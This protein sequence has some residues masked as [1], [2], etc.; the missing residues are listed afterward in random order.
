MDWRNRIGLYGSYFFGMAAIGFTLPYLPLYLSQKGLSD[1]SIGVVSTLAALSGLAQFPI[2]I[3]S[4]RIG[5]RKPF[6]IAALA[7]VA[8][9]TI[10][11][12]SAQDVIWLGFLVVLFAENGISR[13]VVESLSGA[14]AAALAP[15]GG[16]G[17]ALG[18]L[19][20]WKPIGIVIMALVGSW[21]SERSGV[22]SILT[23]I[24]ILQGLAVAAA[25]LIHETGEGK[26]SGD[27]GRT[28]EGNREPA[29]DRERTAAKGWIPKDRG[30]WAFVAAMILY[31]AANAP[32][33]V[34]LGLF[35]KRDLQAPDRMLAYAFVVSMVAWMLVVWPAGWLADRWGR[36]PLL[37]VGWTI[38]ALRLALVALVR[39]P[40]LA[41]ANQA[42]DGLGN[43]L[44]AVVAAAWMT[45]RLA[46]P[47]RAGEA[48]VIVGS[49]LV[50]GSAIG[51]AVSGF[52]VEPL[53]FRGLFAVLA[54][55][56]AVATSI[57]VA[58]VPETTPRHVK[59]HD[60]GG[61]NPRAAASDLAPSP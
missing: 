11:L 46:D 57:V 19:R 50:L 55:V 25:L 61:L 13:A 8:L 58:F 28:E 1:R 30:L 14:E 21:M 36:R 29:W 53:G 26:T 4:D 7:V 60:R 5:W 52:L 32:G 10:L 23:P 34:Y 35:L 42:L 9:A 22:A 16:V 31:H 51:P 17:A 33:G 47:R 39:S 49:C 45:D 40:G 18:V 56:G 20:F 27:Q 43:G 6:L 15:K 3:W 44:F 24:A 54:G 2:G 12:R 59:A 41:V 37:V 48:Q 38:M